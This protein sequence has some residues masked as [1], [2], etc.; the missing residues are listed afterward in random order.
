MLY[1]FSILL[2]NTTTNL[3]KIIIKYKEKGIRFVAI[4]H[5]LDSLRFDEKSKKTFR[6]K[7]VCKEDSQ[8]LNSMNYVIV[9]NTS[10]KKELV[11]KGIKEENIIVLQLFDYLIDNK[12]AEFIDCN[13]NNEYKKTVIIAGNLSPYKAKYLKDINR[14]NVKFNLYGAGFEDS[15]RGNNIEYYGKFKPDELIEHLKGDF[16]LI[17]DGETIDTCS[18]SFGNYLRYNNPHKASLYLTAGIPIIV[19]KESAL[20]EFVENNNVGIS[21]DSLYDIKKVLDNISNEQYEEMKENALKISKKTRQG[22][23]LKQSINSILDKQ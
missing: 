22:L 11:K 17:W 12:I 18:G 10:M 3:Y 23:Y 15:M 4:I 20:K 14:V 19:W 16:G 2:L 9:H 5:D 8:L 6:Y 21:V 7:R 1:L 13:H